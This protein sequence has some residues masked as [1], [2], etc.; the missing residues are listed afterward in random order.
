MNEVTIRLLLLQHAKNV[1]T[2]AQ[3][4]LELGLHA[5]S[6]HALEP[7]DLFDS[8]LGSLGLHFFNVTLLFVGTAASVFG[9]AFDLQ[10]V[11]YKFFQGIEIPSTLVVLSFGVA[12]MVVFDCGIYKAQSHRKLSF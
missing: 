11:F 7:L 8:V 3:P 2:L 12:I 9:V 10:F 1:Q 4:I 6:C 5:V